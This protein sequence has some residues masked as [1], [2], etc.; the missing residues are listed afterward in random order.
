[1]VGGFLIIKIKN[2]GRSSLPKEWNGISMQRRSSP[3]IPGARQTVFEQKKFA[4]AWHYRN[5][6]ADFAEFQARKLVEDLESN[7]AHA[8]VSIILGKK[9]VEVKAL[10]ANK[11]YF[12]RWYMD[13]Y[14]DDEDA[15]IAIGDDRTDEDMF[16]A[17]KERAHTIKVGEPDGTHAKYFVKSQSQV[18]RILK[19]FT[20]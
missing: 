10:E 13:R 7:L 20:T 11:G 6:P 16:L 8:P 9:V 15:I 17:L 14:T 18:E 5:S 19:S 3:I 1:M 4:I 12:S 2:G